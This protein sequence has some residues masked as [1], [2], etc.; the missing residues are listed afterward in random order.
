LAST[1][2]TPSRTCAIVTLVV[3]AS[4]S[5]TPALDAE[6]HSL[7]GFH[8][9]CHDPLL[10]GGLMMLRQSW[11]VDAADEQPSEL[12]SRHA[13]RKP[14]RPGSRTVDVPEL[15]TLRC[16]STGL[17]GNLT[18]GGSTG[19]AAGN[20]MLS[21]ISAP[22]HIVPSLPGTMASQFRR[23]VL[24]ST[25]FRGRA[26]KPAGWSLRHCLRYSA[27]RAN[28]ID[29]LGAARGRAARPGERRRAARLCAPAARRA[30][31]RLNH[32]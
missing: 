12:R 18:T 22:S 28:A 7:E 17:P 11:P 16:H 31:D 13:P 21:G 24:P 6:P 30:R 32:P 25:F 1:S 8:A 14:A 2:C 15:H 20:S 3:Q 5:R 4:V 26:T 9:P 23:S 27:R 29:M 19:Y 10:S